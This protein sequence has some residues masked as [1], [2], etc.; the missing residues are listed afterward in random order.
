MKKFFYLQFA[1]FLAVTCAASAQSVDEIIAANLKA[2]GIT[3]QT[4]CYIDGEQSVMGQSAPLKYWFN[5]DKKFR[6]EQSTQGMDVIIARDGEEC[7]LSYP[8]GIQ[9]FPISELDKIDKSNSFFTLIS[10][11]PLANYKQMGLKVTYQGTDLIDG[12]TCHIIQVDYPNDLRINIFI[13]PK[14]NLEVKY[15]QIIPSLFEINDEEIDEQTRMVNA[16]M[17]PILTPSDWKTFDGI[18]VPTKAEAQIGD[19]MTMTFSIK[20]VKFN[21]KFD[22]KLFSKPE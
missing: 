22:N 5:F 20:D 14:T 4:S 10:N 6:L 17:Q 15:E 8:N 21:Q 9:G 16:L 2:R 7:W 13:D 1:L 18:L 3:Q 19:M 12:K 11:C